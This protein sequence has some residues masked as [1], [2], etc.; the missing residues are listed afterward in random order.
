MTDRNSSKARF[1][2]QIYWLLLFLGWVPWLAA[3]AYV[4]DP[5]TVTR[6]GVLLTVTETIV[7]YEQQGWGHPALGP[8][9]L[10]GCGALVAVLWLRRYAYL[11]GVGFLFCSAFIYLF[12]TAGSST[13]FETGLHL[14]YAALSFGTVY[15]F[16]R[17]GHLLSP[18]FTIFTAVLFLETPI[19]WT[20]SQI[21][22]RTDA[23]GILGYLFPRYEP[24][25]ID[26]VLFLAVA[27]L[28]RMIWLIIRDNRA[29]MASLSRPV[30]RQT[31]WATLRL[32]YP[33]P[34]IFAAG[35]FAWFAV[36]NLW[37]EPRLVTEIDSATDRARQ[38]IMAERNGEVIRPL[39]YLE[40]ALG[41]IRR[42]L[43]GAL[44]AL[45][46]EK[47]DPD[48]TGE[49]L[50][51][52]LDRAV[53]HDR[54]PKLKLSACDA[55][56]M[57]SMGDCETATAASADFMEYALRT[58][59]ER[60]VCS[61][62]AALPES[63][64]RGD[65]T[66]DDLRQAARAAIIE[67][68]QAW[69]D[70]MIKKTEVT[71]P[72][73]HREGAIAELPL[74][75][76]PRPPRD[77]LERALARQNRAQAELAR[78]RILK[79]L[80]T[81]EETGD[82][83]EDAPAQVRAAMERG[84]PEQALPLLDVPKCFFLNIPCVAESSIKSG[85]NDAMKSARTGIFDGI[86]TELEEITEGTADSAA[87]AAKQAGLMLDRKTAAAEDRAEAA[88]ASSFR[89][90]RNLS[91][92]ATIYSLIILLKTMMIVFSRVIFAPNGAD[93]IT[94]QFL[95][96]QPV[97]GRGN[98]VRHGQT[99]E[100]D[101]TSNEAFFVSRSGVTLEGPPPARRR[102]LG[103]RYPV[104]RI[105]ADKWYLNR[106]DGNRQGADEFSAHLK[107]DE[108]AEL[109]TWQLQPGERVVFR[110]AD[111]IG[112][113]ENLRVG[114]VAS[115]SISTLILGRMI[116]HF[117]EG[118]GMLIL[119]TTAASRISA[120]GGPASAAERPAPM[121]KLVAWGSSTHFN[122]VAALTVTDT[123]FSGY[124]LRKRPEDNVIW[125][126]STQRGEGPGAGIMR[127]VKSFLLPL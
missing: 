127:F 121:S 82:K 113:S 124:N 112:M 100:I 126:S 21:S 58:A 115:L 49:A 30:K 46:D 77:P 42:E 93:S 35:T 15:L 75:W 25:V 38:E 70:D 64:A 62:R 29:F 1:A 45:P 57:R 23:A 53:P 116:Y 119:R 107:V 9:T 123:F 61:A 111:F 3:Y 65:A 122:I 24:S 20:V 80:N 11:W 118:P 28:V 78:Q 108:P 117:A 86:E 4:L 32:W 97:E 92:L 114:R 26:A 8:L 36:L 101:K 31:A 39:D 109:V 7:L 67:Q 74:F 55:P 56:Q 17:H 27:V 12:N 81:L 43:S 104:A 73:L 68:R 72:V 102:P 14:L 79:A 59:R 47:F 89:T 52:S 87:E 94:A 16:L 91:L 66:S 34:L 51:R 13:V 76:S 5:G 106:I 37:I 54:L 19:A 69:A 88:L 110:F 71:H 85:A 41:M 105:L 90:W 22:G 60:A 103:W 98:M 84:Y 2:E 50:G 99:L 44:D 125:D 18:A 120:G 6:D 40:V 95:P 63:A 83:V 33:M 48:G 96:D 10:A